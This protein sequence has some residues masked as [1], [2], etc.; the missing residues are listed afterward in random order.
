MKHILFTLF[1]LI[2]F[3]CGKSSSNGGGDA[4][5]LAKPTNDREVTGTVGGFAPLLEANV[6]GG[7]RIRLVSPIEGETIDLYANI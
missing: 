7:C 2:S 3:S 1:L 6:T 5:P 4:T